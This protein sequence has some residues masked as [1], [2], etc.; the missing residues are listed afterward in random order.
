MDGLEA[1]YGGEENLVKA[2]LD[3]VPQYLQPR[4]GVGQG[5]FPA[6][7][8]AMSSEPLEASWV[9]EGAAKFLAAKP[10][11][12]RPV[13]GAALKALRRFGL[14]TLGQVAAMRPAHLAD[15]FGPEGLL[16]WNL[17]HGRDDSPLIPIK[18]HETIT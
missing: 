11:S 4:A 12:L 3:A 18:Y 9:P 13:S 5:K 17:A 8:A 15:Q 14:H 2:L 6:M 10:V 16:S 1:L 7:V